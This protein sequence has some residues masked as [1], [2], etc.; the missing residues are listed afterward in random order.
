MER[1]TLSAP[2]KINLF[3][4]VNGTR[5]DGYHEITT[6]MQSVTLADTLTV[7]KTEGTDFLLTCSDG[8]LSCG[9]ENLVSRAAEAF[10]TAVGTRFGIRAHLEKEIPM[11]AGM[12]GGSADAAAMLRA[13]NALSERKADEETLCRIAASLG[14]DVPFCLHRG[15]MLCTGIG[16]KMTPLPSMPHCFLVA[17]IRNGDAVPTGEAYR[18]I[19]ALRY[20]PE[21]V[22][23]TA[24][25]LRAGSLPLLLPSLFNRFEEVAPPIS[26]GASILRGHG[27]SA[28]LLC[29]SGAAFFGVFDNEHD[30]GE[31]KRD[32]LL[33]GYAAWRTEPLAE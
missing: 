21:S 17:A 18:R 28:V 24:E 19:D 31:A 29:G 14:A 9:P 30:A 23:R 22:G 20:V 15:A 6:V 27:A 13:L 12:G 8:R 11:Q 26:R 1:V 7:E 10:F 16:E 33:T 32:L 5:P 3:L 25:A 2:A 4:E